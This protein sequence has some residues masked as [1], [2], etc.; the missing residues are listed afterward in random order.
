MLRRIQERLIR[1]LRWSERYT[2]TDMVYLV[3][4]SVWLSGSS[5]MSGIISFLLA[6]AFANL[7]TNDAYGTFK[8]ALTLFGIL[9]VA[10]LR[11][12]DTAVTRGAAR[13][14]DGTVTMGLRSKILYSLLGSLAAL[15]VAAYY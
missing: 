3:L 10:C 5:V 12:M 15:A 9:C 6:L 11:G 4:G 8:Y 13:G 2:K 7:F 1:V 14:N